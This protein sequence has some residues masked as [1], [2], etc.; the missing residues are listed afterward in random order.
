MS[1]SLVFE[2]RI[3]RHVLG[4]IREFFAVTLP[5]FESLCLQELKSLP[6]SD[7]DAQVVHGGVAFKGRIHDC[8]QANLNLRTAGRILMRIDAFQASNF[9][10]L[11]KKIAGIPWELY[12]QPAP[13]PEFQVTSR[14][15]RIIHTEAIAQ[16]FR[17]GIAEKF[18]TIDGPAVA[19]NRKAPRP[20]LFVRA[21]KDHF[22]VSLDSSG[23]NLYKRGI[24]TQAA[25]APLRETTAA[26]IL[27]LAGYLGTEPLLDPMCGSGTFSLEAAMRVNN[28]P[29]GWFRNFAFTGWPA[30]SIN[31]KRWQYI[32]AERGKSITTSEQALI[33]AS[34]IE[35]E[36]CRLLENS[37][38][39]HGLSK[40]IQVFRR[41]FFDIMPSEVV[42][43]TGL[44]VINPPYGQRIGTP[45]DSLHLFQ[46][47]CK[48]LEKDYSAW[49][50][51]L[52][53]PQFLLKQIPFP[54]QTHPIMHGGLKIY[55]AVGRIP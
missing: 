24:K 15:S 3:K 35:D 37:A 12:L 13:I 29:A 5:G 26:A 34:D 7:L 48:K 51:A 36:A 23:K 55:A 4:R 49:K 38:A 54:A 8:Y 31:N 42:N 1:T 14:R 11:E 2:K 33:F 43:Q 30:F 21:V 53:V 45:Q 6:L 39:E 22:T 41:D 50:F 28:V 40:P 44:V 9:N 27:M 19:D 10:R 46:R 20:K 32:K 17:S 47:V 16:R 18:S 25:E 52:I